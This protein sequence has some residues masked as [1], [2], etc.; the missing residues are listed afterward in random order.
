MVEINVSK[1]AKK[2]TVED[3]ISIPETAQFHVRCIAIGLS[4]SGTLLRII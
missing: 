1:I 3:Q 2:L 4:T